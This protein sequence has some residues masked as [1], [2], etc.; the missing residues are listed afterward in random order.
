MNI[1][2]RVILWFRLVVVP[3]PRRG[4]APRVRTSHRHRALVALTAGAISLVLLHLGLGIAAELILL[5]K[6]PGYADKELR[7]ARQEA[8]NP[9][10]PRVV[11]L[12]TSRTGFG[13]HAGRIRAELGGPVTVFNFGIPASG[14]V[15]HL[16]YTRRLLDE[17][18][19]PDLLLV[20]VLPPALANLHDGPLEAR[21]TY[22]DRLRRDEAALAAGHGFPA[23]KVRRQWAESVVNP[24]YTLRF[25]IMGRL[26]P[27]ALPWH[28]RFDWSRTPDEFGWSTPMVEEVTPEQARA[29][30]ARAA[31]EYRDV[32]S[33][34]D[35]NGPAA[36][37]LG[38]LLALCRERGVPVKLVLM[39]E[40]S[41][42][43]AFYPLAASRQLYSLLNRLRT[44]Y[45][46]ELIDARE[47]L[48]D[49]VFT[50][51][52]HMLRP[53]A[54]AFSDRL[55]REVIRP[56]LCERLTR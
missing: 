23:E 16:I 29:G 14:P 48:P 22:G 6:D 5:I 47:W 19:R 24:W 50:D 21:F 42:F 41:G 46:C 34:L 53:G 38:E 49:A 18:H 13:F 43:R 15:T 31:S 12:G 27:S 8:A 32:L 4:S 33:Y 25:Q 56:F 44:E 9:G 20:E 17:G 39:P 10:G 37:A 30:L 26:A 51:G 52:H 45:G 1:A 7:L 54:E 35:G 11:M 28:L 55:T 2:T 36:V 40:S 3:R